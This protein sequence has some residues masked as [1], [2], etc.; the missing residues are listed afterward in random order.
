MDNGDLG[1]N[2]H[3][4]YMCM[5]ACVFLFVCVYVCIYIPC[6][7]FTGPFELNFPFTNKVMTM[8]VRKREPGEER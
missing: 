5:Y 2:V 8:Y 4:V 6:S 1:V 3:F 7:P